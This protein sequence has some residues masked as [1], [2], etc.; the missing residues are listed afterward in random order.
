MLLRLPFETLFEYLKVR[1]RLVQEN[2]KARVQPPLSVEPSM[3]SH[4]S[5]IHSCCTLASHARTSMQSLRTIAAQL[6]PLGRQAAFYLAAAV[7]DFY[8]PWPQMVR[9]LPFANRLCR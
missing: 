7:S 9:A 2:S 8:I 3:S 6:R 1:H 4:L 5:C